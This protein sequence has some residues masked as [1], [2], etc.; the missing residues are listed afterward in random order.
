MDKPFFSL[1]DLAE[2]YSKSKRTIHR[3]T[4]NE[5]NPLP[6]PDIQQSGMS[7]L[8]RRQTI[9]DWEASLGT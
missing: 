6:P 5:T 1:T 3:W 2:R 7:C 4:K 9:L 8:W